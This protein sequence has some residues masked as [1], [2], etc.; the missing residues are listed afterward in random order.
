MSWN[1]IRKESAKT[2]ADLLSNNNNLKTLNL[3]HNNLGDLVGQYIGLSL[4][5]NAALTNLDISYNNILPY[6]IMVRIYVHRLS[7]GV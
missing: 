4:R 2:L 6:G 3:A 5:T 7:K 1:N